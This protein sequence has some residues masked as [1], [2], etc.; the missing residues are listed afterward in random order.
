MS[1]RPAKPLTRAEVRAAIGARVAIDAK[2][3]WIWKGAKQRG[4]GA[5]KWGGRSAPMQRAHRAAWEAWNGSIRGGLHVLHRCDVKACC[6]PAHLFLGTHKENMADLHAKGKW[7]AHPNKGKRVTGPH[8][9][10]VP[11]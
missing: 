3:C 7:P 8:Q 4:Y 1:P 6:N 11:A 9:Q 10:E 5:L 2:G